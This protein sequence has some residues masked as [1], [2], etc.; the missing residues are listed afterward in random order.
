PWSS[1]P[2]EIRETADKRASFIEKCLLTGVPVDLM[3]RAT[4]WHCHRPSKK[5]SSGIAGAG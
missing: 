1:L 5:H 2:L 4:R 3:M